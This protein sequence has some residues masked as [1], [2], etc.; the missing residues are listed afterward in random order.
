[1]ASAASKLVLPSEEATKVVKQRASTVYGHPGPIYHAFAHIATGVLFQ[2][3]IEGEVVDPQEGVMMLAGMKIARHTHGNYQWDNLVDLAG[4]SNVAHL[5]DA[6][7][8][9]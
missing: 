7:E 8:P 1:M 9:N 3:L 2:K 5:V 4:Y 6:W